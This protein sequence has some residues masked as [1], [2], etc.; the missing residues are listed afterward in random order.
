MATDFWPIYG[1]RD[2]FFFTHL[3]SCSSTD[4]RDILGPSQPDECVLLSD[5]YVAY[6]SWAKQ[7]SLK[8]AQCR[9]HARRNV[10][11]AKNIEPAHAEKSLEHIAALYAF[12]EHI[13]THDLR[14]AARPAWR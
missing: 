3:P 11:E 7:I 2:E 6:A 9:A 14:G 1:E 4:V 12:E 13:I 8:R 5:D 10:F